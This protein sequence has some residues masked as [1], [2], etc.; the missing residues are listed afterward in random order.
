MSAL[1]NRKDSLISEETLEI[2]NNMNKLK[3]GV[4]DMDHDYDTIIK[5]MQKLI[6]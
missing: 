3:R 1:S 2:V 4:A 5:T 6:N